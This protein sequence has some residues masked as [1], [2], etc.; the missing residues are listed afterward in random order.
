MQ[1]VGSVD[2]G[3][4]TA[5]SLH[6]NRS[7]VRRGHHCFLIVENTQQC[8]VYSPTAWIPSYTTGNCDSEDADID[9]VYDYT[10]RAGEHLSKGSALGTV[11]QYDRNEEASISNTVQQRGQQGDGES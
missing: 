4:V 9:A 11:E 5:H 6:I 7:Q 1:D 10:V 2:A 3:D 8:S